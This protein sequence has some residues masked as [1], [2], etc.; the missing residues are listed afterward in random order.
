M[1]FNSGLFI[2]QEVFSGDHSKWQQ[3]GTYGPFYFYNGTRYPYNDFHS[4]FITE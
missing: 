2:F 4:V 1:I 3:I